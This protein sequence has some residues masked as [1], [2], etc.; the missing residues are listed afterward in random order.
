MPVLAPVLSSFFISI[1]RKTILHTNDITAATIPNGL[2][3]ELMA[4][5][6]L[7]LAISHNKTQAIASKINHDMIINM[8]TIYVLSTI[9]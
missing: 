9:I 4:I 8:I 3:N 6:K 2:H 1:Y 7:I 5:L